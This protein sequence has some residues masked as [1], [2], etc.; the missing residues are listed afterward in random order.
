M[1]L[2]L[3]LGALTLL[4]LCVVE[5]TSGHAFNP[6]QDDAIHRELTEEEKKERRKERMEQKKKKKQS[7]L[8]K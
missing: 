7:G 4:L 2:T 3:T 6:S 1:K 8:E 5:E